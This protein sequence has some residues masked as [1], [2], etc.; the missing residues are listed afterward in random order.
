[1]RTDCN[2]LSLGGWGVLCH[3]RGQ[4]SLCSQSLLVLQCYSPSLLEVG[5]GLSPLIAPHIRK[6]FP[7]FGSGAG[8]DS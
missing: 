2:R 3:F 6:E 1:M 8:A 4:V 5:Q 7:L